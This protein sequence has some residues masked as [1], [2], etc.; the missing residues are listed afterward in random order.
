VLGISANGHRIAVGSW[1]GSQPANYIIDLRNVEAGRGTD[2]ER[3]TTDP[4]EG[5]LAPL[6][7]RASRS[8]ISLR[9]NFQGIYA[10]GE[11]ALLSKKDHVLSFVLAK[12][13]EMILQDRGRPNSGD[14]KPLRFSPAAGP[15]G[16]R[17]ELGVATWKDGSRAYL[18]SRGLLHLKSSDPTLPEISLALS[19]GPLAGWDSEME[20]FGPDF[21]FYSA[22]TNN[23]A[24]FLSAIRA[25]TQRLR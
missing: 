22:A 11:L 3:F 13:G 7:H 16:T 2:W 1:H 8:G 6:I 12:N 18:D 9:H 20:R 15:S 19:N 24:H 21:F 10:N 25:F 14:G 23:A 4:Q 17:F 5:L